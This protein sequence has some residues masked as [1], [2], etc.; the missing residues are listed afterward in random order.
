MDKPEEILKKAREAKRKTQTEV[1]E[2]IG[3][4][5][6]MYQKIESGEFPKYKREQ[7]LKLDEFLGTNIYE[8]IY[9]QD[10]EGEQ[11]IH[12][13]NNYLNKR[14][15][16]K[17]GHTEEKDG[18]A[19]VPISAQAGYSKK[20]SDEGFISSLE[21]IYIP[22]FPYRGEKFLY[23]EVAGDSMSPTLEEGFHVLAENVEKTDW[24]SQANY[25][26]YVIVTVD[27]IMIKRIFR[28]DDASWVIISDNEEFY[29]QFVLPVSK[30]K[31]LWKVKRKIDW[32][33]AP[34][35]KFE[36]KI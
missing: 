9:E 36:I 5:L 27:Q 30:I 13:D 14:R 23:F 16:E 25:Y 19:F 29:P 24:A 7:I 18:I 3:V 12:T 22:G 1:A 6:R 26:I 10:S 21:K 35:K 4:G 11:T 15:K 2:A 8:L 34:P 17:N 31:E 28:K 33:M 20:I 32:K